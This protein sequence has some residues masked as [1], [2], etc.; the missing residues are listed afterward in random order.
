MTDKCFVTSKLVKEQIGSGNI[1][2]IL[3]K[4]NQYIV[5]IMRSDHVKLSEQIQ[6]LTQ[7]NVEEKQSTDDTRFVQENNKIMKQLQ[8]KQNELSEQIKQIIKS[9]KDLKLIMID[10]QKNNNNDN[11]ITKMKLEI[12]SIKQLILNKN[13]EN[14]NISSEES[15]MRK[16]MEKSVKLP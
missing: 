11:D 8:N 5:N 7:N 15:K 3:Q 4:E 9:I 2:Y 12:K 14:K 13:D 1:H 16:W 10:E 6:Q